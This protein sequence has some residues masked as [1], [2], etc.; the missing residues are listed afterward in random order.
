MLSF[1]LSPPLAVRKEG[2]TLNKY[3]GL[4]YRLGPTRAQE[5]EKAHFLWVAVKLH[6]LVMQER[7]PTATHHP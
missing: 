3:N 7:F 1:R 2:K 6:G 4:F 5:M